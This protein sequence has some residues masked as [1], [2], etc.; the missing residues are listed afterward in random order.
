MAERGITEIV[1]VALQQQPEHAPLTQH[2][3]ILSPYRVTALPDHLESLPQLNLKLR[4][5][6]R[7]DQEGCLWTNTPSVC[8]TILTFCPSKEGRSGYRGAG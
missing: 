3:L 8:R 6:Y 7:Q 2:W 1:G 5:D 4:Y